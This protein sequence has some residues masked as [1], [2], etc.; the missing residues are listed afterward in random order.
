MNE[1][2][3]ADCKALDT[4]FFVCQFGTPT[5]RMINGTFDW[6]VELTFNNRQMENSCQANTQRE[7]WRD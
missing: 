7:R 4:G 3:Q 1:A 5:R 6:T 2:Q